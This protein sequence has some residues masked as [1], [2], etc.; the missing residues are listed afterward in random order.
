MKI[1]PLESKPAVAG[2]AGERKARATESAGGAPEPSA[3]VE[4]SAAGSAIASVLAD[5]SFDAQKVERISRAIRDGSYRINAEAIA[6][7]LIA[8][9]REL[10]ESG[11]N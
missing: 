2:T 3:K 6:D 11:K 4:L 5:G 9:S 7:K 1:V 10:L 8:N